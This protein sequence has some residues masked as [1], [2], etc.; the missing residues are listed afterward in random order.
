METV[1]GKTFEGPTRL[2][3]KRYVACTFKGEVVYD[4][5]PVPRLDSVNFDGVALNFD[6]PAS[7]T[8]DFLANIATNPHG[9]EA[10]IRVFDAILSLPM[11]VPD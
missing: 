7:D 11:R 6:G 3:T 4:G 2:E 9:R 10:V 8:L 5:R 1:V